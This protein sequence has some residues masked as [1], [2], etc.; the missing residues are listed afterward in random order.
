MRPYDFG[1]GRWVFIDWLGVEPGYGTKWP[2]KEKSE[3]AGMQG[4]PSLGYCVPEGIRLKVH[5]PDVV[6]EFAIPL[7]RPW[8]KG[9]AAYATFLEDNGRFRCW[10][11]Y[12]DGMAYAESEDG[13]HWVK[14]NLG[15]WEFNGSTANNILDFGIHGASVFI[16]P[17]APDSERYKMVGC[18]WTK[19][20]KAV[21]GAV[22]PDGVHWTPLSEPV[23]RH[24]H[25][26]TQSI[27]LFD[28]SLGRY[29]L[30]TRQMDGV[31]QRR[32]VNRSV[33]ED[34]RHFPPSEPVVE[35]NPFDPPD[36]DIYCNGYSKWPGAAAHIM[37]L[38]VYKHTSDTI[39]VHLA[40]SRD[41]VRWHRPQGTMPW[42][43]GGPSHSDPYPS[44]YACAG[45]LPTAPG[46]WSTYIGV[47][48]LAHNEPQERLARP[49]GILRVRMRAHGFMSLSSESRGEFWTIPFTL[50]SDAI[51]LNTKTRYSGFVR[52]EILASSGGRTGAETAD[53]R[54]IAGYSLE[55]G[56]PITGDY[57][58]APLAWKDGHRLDK[59]RGR[60]VRLHFVL[61][62]ADL[63][64]MRF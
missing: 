46:E 54:P 30:Y 37:R 52:A 19:D 6:P 33:S 21:I 17:S 11:E 34:F 58:D 64:A 3:R 45:I 24:H 35:C 16:D 10:Y 57:L 18:L 1:K 41:G 2:E 43:D 38:S 8:E 62:K 7:D 13:A 12:F 59:L 22:F 25:A 32:G 4:E 49:A 9:M 60:T 27:C 14:P 23:L 51:H 48:H 55:E 31:M 56:V 42:I 50:D 28:P 61:Y 29:V 53:N 20:E 39:N 26:D 15:Q 5:T 44:V 47:A 36:W 63:Y 40:T